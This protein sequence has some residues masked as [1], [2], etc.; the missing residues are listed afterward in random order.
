MDVTQ[1]CSEARS[2]EELVRTH[3]PLVRQLVTQLA[4]RMPRHASRDD[5]VSAGML[6]LAQAA[7]TFDPSRGVPFHVYAATRIR[8]ALLDELRSNDWASRQVRAKARRMDG[9]R[10]RLTA[11][12]GRPPTIDELAQ[13]LDVEPAA[14]LSLAHD[15]HRA[16]VVNYDSVVAGGSGETVL[17]AHEDDPELELLDRERKAYLVDAVRALPERLRLVVIGYFFEDRSMQEIG[18]ELGVSQSRISQLRTQALDLLRDGLNAQ[19]E[20]GAVAPLPLPEG[21]F[22]RRK[23]AYHRAIAAS[24]TPRERLDSRPR[25]PSP[26]AACA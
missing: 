10:E 24:S 1:V 13:E 20:P 7:R 3:L 19:L 5:L 18:Q 14:I 17:L 11:S 23:A 15:L 25:L 22:A 2:E 21:R 4:S 26:V 12:L 8:G 6:G 16:V 9:A